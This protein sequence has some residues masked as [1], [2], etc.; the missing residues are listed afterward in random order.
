MYLSVSVFGTATVS[1]CERKVLRD[2]FSL[3]SQKVSASHNKNECFLNLLST[4]VYNVY[5]WHL[6]VQMPVYMWL[7]TCA[8][9]LS[10]LSY[11]L[12]PF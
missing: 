2:G 6:F 12:L 10:L 5:K 7:Y 3:V 9:R 11:M 4:L 8:V 1:V